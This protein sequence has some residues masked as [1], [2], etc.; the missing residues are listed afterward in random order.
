[1]AKAETKRILRYP[2]PPEIADKLRLPQEIT[3]KLTA[4]A[5]DERQARANAS[6]VADARKG[7][8][9]HFRRIDE[10][11]RRHSQAAAT[12]LV[13]VERLNDTG[14]WMSVEANRLKATGQ[15]HKG[16]KKTDIA[17]LLE[18]RLRNASKTDDKLRRVEFRHIRNKL[19]DW[20]IWPV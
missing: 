16:M 10:F 6:K 11:Y 3:Q 15:I 20:G 19:S 2:A 1:M 9:G 13:N 12:T 7:I 8:D 4:L 14:K 18:K 17:R 5:A